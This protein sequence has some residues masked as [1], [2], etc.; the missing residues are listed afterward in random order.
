MHG[1]RVET[2]SVR[3]EALELSEDKINSLIRSTLE[4][5]GY[6]YASWRLSVQYENGNTYVTVLWD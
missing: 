4:S 1:K 6:T 3:A 2:V 5:Y